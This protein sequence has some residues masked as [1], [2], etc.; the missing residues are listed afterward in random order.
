MLTTRARAGASA[1]PARLT[2]SCVSA[3]IMHL[4]SRPISRALTSTARPVRDDHNAT[5]SNGRSGDAARGDGRGAAWGKRDFRMQLAHHND[6]RAAGGTR[7][8]RA[9][10][11]AWPIREPSPHKSA[12]AC[13]RAKRDASTPALSYAATPSTALSCGDGC[14]DDAIRRT[15]LATIIAEHS[16][17]PFEGHP[18]ICRL[19]CL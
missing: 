12:L 6:C 8:M 13:T 15:A 4:T 3:H 7:A 17:W 18:E 11:R 16:D 14:R 10:W 5:L 19:D 2:L 9:G 1:G